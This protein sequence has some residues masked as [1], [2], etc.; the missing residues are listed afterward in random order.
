MLKWGGGGSF[1]FSASN[2]SL[3]FTISKKGNE[4]IMKAI[5]KFLYDLVPL[6][7][8]NDKGYD[9]WVKINSDN[10]PAARIKFALALLLSP[11]SSSTSWGGGGD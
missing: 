10:S 7:L 8:K 5:E 3:V 9:S 11:P 4:A 6:N 2:K 1:F